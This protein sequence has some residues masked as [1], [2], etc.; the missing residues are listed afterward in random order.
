VLLEI[1]KSIRLGEPVDGIWEFVRDPA[2]VAGCIPNIRQFVQQGDASS[3]A[4]TIEDKLGPF[5]L[6]VPVTIDVSE[7]PGSR[8]MT[9]AVAGNDKR[10]QARVRGEVAATVVPDGEGSRIELTSN[11]EVLGRL[12]ALGAVP[13]RRRADQIFEVFVQNLSRQLGG[14][15][16]QSAG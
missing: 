15:G 13:M 10:G 14:S 6:E 5:R 7:D 11:L 16:G 9:A 4:A 1:N 8:R 3:F 2:R 12:A